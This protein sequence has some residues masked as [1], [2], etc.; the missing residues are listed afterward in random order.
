MRKLCL[1][2]IY[3]FLVQK[4]SL[5][6]HYS[7][8]SVVPDNFFKKSNSDTILGID[9]SYHQKNIKWSS[10]DGIDFV[11]IKATEGVSIRDVKF[12]QNW[13]S[14]KKRGLIRG[15][16]HFYRPYVGAK[17]QFINFK[18]MVNLSSGDLPPVLD[19]EIESRN[20]KKLKSDLKIW[21]NLAEKHYGVTPIIYCSSSFYRKYFKEPYFDRYTFWIANYVTDDLNKIHKNWHFLQHTGFGK[22]GGISTHVDKNIFKGDFEDL[23]S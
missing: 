16:Y 5:N 17:E 13:D 6:N 8:A 12:N 15:A 14:A 3:I 11:F 20:S 9:I 4:Q 19:A 22:V 7:S 10:I 21:L 18:K 2:F 23:I 1:I